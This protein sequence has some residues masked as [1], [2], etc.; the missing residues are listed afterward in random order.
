MFPIGC[1]KIKVF[2]IRK[3]FGLFSLILGLI[4][5]LFLSRQPRP[6]FFGKFYIKFL[7]TD[8]EVQERGVNLCSKCSLCNNHE[9]SPSH[10]FLDFLVARQVWSWLQQIFFLHLFFLLLYK[11][12]IKNG[13]KKRCFL[14]SYVYGY[15][16]FIGNIQ[17]LSLSNLQSNQEGH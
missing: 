9:E 5:G 12:M 7:L 11:K 15:I 8:G 6:Q 3:L 14:F 10:P 1:L 4:F 13:K 16:T 2:S 17:G